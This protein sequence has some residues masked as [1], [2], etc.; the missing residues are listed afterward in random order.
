M[1]VKLSE[2]SLII[3]YS[4]NQAVR[5]LRFR[6]EDI[7]PLPDRRCV[8]KFR[9]MFQYC[10]INWPKKKTNPNFQIPSL[11]IYLKSLLELT[12]Q[13]STKPRWEI[14]VQMLK[15]LLWFFLFWFPHYSLKATKYSN[16]NEMQ[17]KLPL[18]LKAA[19]EW[20]K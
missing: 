7:D 6:E 14:S 16:N 20:N 18:L 8:W 17:S 13:C 11:F 2:P 3:H 12:S 10:Y 1:E 15:F 9:S 4:I 19:P 5:Y